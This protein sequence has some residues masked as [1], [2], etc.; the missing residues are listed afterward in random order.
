MKATTQEEIF[1]DFS[2]LVFKARRVLAV[3]LEL[4][5]C[6]EVLYSLLTPA[7]P[8]TMDE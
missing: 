4:L 8:W 1:V 2:W 5:V 6:R 7:G 3:F